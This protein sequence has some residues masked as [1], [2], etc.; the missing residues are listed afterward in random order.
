[1]PDSPAIVGQRLKAAQEALEPTAA[2]LCSEIRINPS[3]WSHFV[4]GERMVTLDVANRLCDR[5][6][7]TL[8]W[9]YRGDP[10]GLPRSLK[11]AA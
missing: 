9:I 4:N 1:M 5:Y 2:A 8:D 6:R 7:L 3:A 10:S 11:I